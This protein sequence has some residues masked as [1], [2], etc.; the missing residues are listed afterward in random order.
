MTG[1]GW[2]LPRGVQIQEVAARG[3][4][5]PPESRWNRQELVFEYPLPTAQIPRVVLD[6]RQNA[7]YVG[8]FLRCQAASG[9][10]L[11]RRARVNALRIGESDQAPSLNRAALSPAP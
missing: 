5:L 8:R 3:G 10:S 11:M 9:S 4:H 6:L 1:V 7:L 2:S